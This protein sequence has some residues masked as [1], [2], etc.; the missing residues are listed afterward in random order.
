MYGNDR[1]PV[2]VHKEIDGTLYSSRTAEVIHYWDSKISSS[3]SVVA[4]TPEGHY[5]KAWI[6]STNLSGTGAHV[7]PI[8]RLWATALVA[9]HGGS[10]SVLE[11]LGV[12]IM[13]QPQSDTPYSMRNSDT[14]WPVKVPF[15]WRTLLMERDG[16]LWMF[17]G[18]YLFGVKVEWSAPMSQ[19]RAIAWAIRKGAWDCS[20]RMLGVEIPGP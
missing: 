20:L 13:H 7:Y 17:K 8:S 12:R 2:R 3:R 6:Y 9:E 16:R 19:R 15:G 4:V 18:F 14:V 1:I 10:D 11:S 5:F